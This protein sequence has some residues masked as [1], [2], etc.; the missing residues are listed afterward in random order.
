MD[1]GTFNVR[2]GGSVSINAA[3]SHNNNVQAPELSLS[4]GDGTSQTG[5]SGGDVLISAGDGS[6]GESMPNLIH[7][8][9]NCCQV[10]TSIL[11]T[12]LQ[13]LL[14][15]AFLAKAE[16]SLSVQEKPRGEVEILLEDLSTFLPANP[17]SMAAI[18][19][20]YQDLEA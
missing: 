16:G 4:A 10:L 18:C 12:T 9:K 15:E 3:N 14:L 11:C 7:N 13:T 6:G 8:N 20:F 19:C 2:S 1:G 5:G 17:K